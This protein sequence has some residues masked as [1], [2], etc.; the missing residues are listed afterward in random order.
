MSAFYPKLIDHLPHVQIPIPG[1][2]G[3]LLQSDYGQLVFFDIPQGAH[4]P[5]H[6]HGE[7]WGC[8]LDG[9]LELTIDGRKRTYRKGDTYHI[10]AGVT[11]EARFPTRCHVIDLFADVDRYKPKK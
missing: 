5:P 8:V 3:R 9:E 4:V 2:E 1:V 10:P 7:Q 6:N 11:H